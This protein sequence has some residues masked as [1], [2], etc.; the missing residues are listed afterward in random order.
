MASHHQAEY[1][2]ICEDQLTEEDEYR[3]SEN[4]N[5]DPDGYCLSCRIKR[6]ANDT[7]TEPESD[8]CTCP[9]DDSNICDW[10]WGN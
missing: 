5:F 3:P 2:K 6:Y 1:C 9:S 8:T 10:C 7:D 4:A